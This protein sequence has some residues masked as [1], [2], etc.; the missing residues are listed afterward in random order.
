[1]ID[2]KKKYKLMSCF[3]S[4]IDCGAVNLDIIK[5]KNTY[6]ASL[7]SEEES[8]AEGFMVRKMRWV[9]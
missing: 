5:K 6:W 2:Y 4:Q 1:M 9:I 7:I 8:Y 3:K